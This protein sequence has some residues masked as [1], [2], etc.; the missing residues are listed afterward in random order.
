VAHFVTENSLWQTEQR[1]DSALLGIDYDKL[2]YYN[3]T[4]KELREI[5]DLVDQ[6]RE[7]RSDNLRIIK[8]QPRMSSI[9]T[10]ERV[11]YEL[12]LSNFIPDLIVLDSADHL[13][14]S[15][16][17]KEFRLDQAEVY[18]NLKTVAD[19]HTLPLLTSTQVRQAEKGRVASSEALAEAYD[20]ARIL[21]IVLTL[22]QLAEDSLE[23]VL[24]VAKN[25]DGKRG[26]EIHLVSEY[27]SMGLKEKR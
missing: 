3:F 12:E 6:V 21:D 8:L 25:R 10:V 15:S 24:K 14:S 26:Q 13:I 19:M 20:K 7:H 18:W 16:K 5:S 2:K 1:Y 9:I 17:F 27:G 22:N 23:L 4:K 11:L